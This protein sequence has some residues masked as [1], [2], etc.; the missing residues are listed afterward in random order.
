MISND[1]SSF[2]LKK[3]IELCFEIIFTS[4]ALSYTFQNVLCL[5]KNLYTTYILCQS[6]TFCA[7]PKDDFHSVNLVFGHFWR[8]SYENPKILCNLCLHFARQD[9]KKRKKNH[10]IK[11][12]KIPKTRRQKYGMNETQGIKKWKTQVI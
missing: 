1:F 10:A 6:Q 3:L 9:G 8:R 11:V 5:S 12:T 7:T 4:N 2:C